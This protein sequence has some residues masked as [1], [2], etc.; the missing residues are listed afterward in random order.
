VYK[1]PD[2]IV[3]IDPA[4]AKGQKEIVNTCPYRVIYWNEELQ[5]PQKCDMCAHL[6]DKGYEV[7]RCVEMCPTGALLFGDLNDPE[8]EISKVMAEQKPESRHPE[9][10]LH[11]RVLYLNNPKTFISGTVVYKDDD[12]CVSG[13]TATLKRDGKV[14]QT[15]V[16]NAFGDFWFDGL[17]SKTDYEI[18]IELDGY[19]TIEAKT[20][21]YASVNMGDLFLEKA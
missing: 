12:M 2:G 5:L 11:E 4:K 16:T 13:A 1:R 3:I 9:Y 18:T 7:P 8:S 19:R 15:Y 17:D 10:Q 14:E 6:L 20:R 21:T